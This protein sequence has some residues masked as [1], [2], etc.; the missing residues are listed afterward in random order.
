MTP[1][2]SN[3]EP[4]EYDDT[5]GDDHDH[6]GHELGDPGPPRGWFAHPLLDALE[7][8]G[9]GGD[10]S[11]HRFEG[12]SVD[13]AWRVEQ[14]LYPYSDHLNIAEVY[15]TLRAVQTLGFLLGGGVTIEGYWIDG[16]EDDRLTVTG[17]RWRT[18]L[19]DIEA[20]ALIRDCMLVTA[21]PSPVVVERL[22]DGA[23]YIWWND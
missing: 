5:L 10:W 20:L 14:A 15:P 23:F 12:L 22:A 13:A 19:Q 3:G 17:V 7:I 1:Y 4:I 18:E 6:F 8:P 9:P 11:F 21:V 2:D 16:R